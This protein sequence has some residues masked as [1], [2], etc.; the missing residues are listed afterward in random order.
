MIDDGSFK[1]NNYKPI[2]DQF[3]SSKIKYIKIDKNS[4]VSSAMNIAIKNA[5]GYYINWLSH[6]DYFDHS[7]IEKQ[8][9]ILNMNNPENTICLSHSI[10]FNETTNY[11]RKI[12]VR[13]F[14]IN[15]KNWLL[16]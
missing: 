11:R 7:K 2:L 16:M 4:G 8:L 10:T 12:N 14:L 15:K 1:S 9:K 13:N 3:K 5:N 6:D